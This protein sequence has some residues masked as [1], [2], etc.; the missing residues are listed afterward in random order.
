M[1]TQS[2]T[3]SAEPPSYR[4]TGA[5]A[6][7]EDGAARAIARRVTARPELLVVL[8]AAALI[9]L[10]NLSINGWANTYY[11]AAVRSMSSSWHD[12]LFASMDRS[13]LMTVDKPPFALLGP[14]ALCAGVRLPSAEHSGSAG[15][16]G[17]GGR[18][19]DVRPRAPAVRQARRVSSPVS[20]SRRRR[21]SW[22]SAAITT[23]TSCSSCCRLPP[24]G[25]RCAR[26]TPGGTRWLV[27][28][29][30]DG[31]ARL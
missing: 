24:S 30:V 10:W 29:G 17:R 3:I 5:D 12:F 22:L 19:S 21:R 8:A 25:S 4:S 18:R 2:P 7:G 13:G 16:D 15:A 6:P 28:S 20:R 31:R 23:L 26:S 1:S 27:W 14:G 9:N 11:A